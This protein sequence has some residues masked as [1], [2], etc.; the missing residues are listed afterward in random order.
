MLNIIFNSIMLLYKT[1]SYWRCLC[2]VKTPNHAKIVEKS[3]EVL[4]V[5]NLPR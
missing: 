2:T 3:K 4:Q 5:F 1:L